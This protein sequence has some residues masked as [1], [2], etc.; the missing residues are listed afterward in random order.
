M[1][2]A[3]SRPRGTDA[4]FHPL[5]ARL[6]EVG[7]VAA[8]NAHVEERIAGHD[9]T[10]SGARALHAMR[11]IGGEPR[12]LLLFLIAGHNT[13]LPDRELSED[14][15]RQATQR[16]RLPHL[17]GKSEYAEILGA[18]GYASWLSMLSSWLVDADSSTAT[19]TSIPKSR[20]PRAPSFA[21]RLRCARHLELAD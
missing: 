3:H 18:Q 15:G 14:A 17:D 7:R 6:R 11:K 5:E 16:A 9:K 10:H 2:T 13:D 19:P 21:V 8:P 4:E 20:V 1:F 12:R